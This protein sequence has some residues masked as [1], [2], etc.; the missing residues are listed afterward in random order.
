[1]RRLC[2]VRLRGLVPYEPSL[3]LQWR[4][5]GLVRE[6]ALPALVLSLQHAPSQGSQSLGR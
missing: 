1:M 6:G 5:A 4:L 2:A 3:A